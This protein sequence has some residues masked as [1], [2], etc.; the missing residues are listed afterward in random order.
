MSFQ[1]L[2]GALWRTGLALLVAAFSAAAL[3]IPA[4]AQRVSFTG[5]DAARAEICGQS[6]K[7]VHVDPGQPLTLR[8]GPRRGRRTL[9]RLDRCSKG[10]WKAVRRIR[11]HRKSGV[12]VRRNLAKNGMAQDLRARLAGSRPAYARIGVG[13]IV[14]IRF[15]AQ[16]VNQNR[17]SIPCLGAPDSQPYPVHGSLIA[18]RSALDSAH[19]AAT[20][21]VHG[22]G[23]SSFFFHFEDVPGYD[24][25]EQQAR[26]GHASIVV[27]R[28]G[29]PAHDDLPDGDATC[30]P[31]QADM[32]DQVIAALRSGSYDLDGEKSL[33]FERVLLAGHSLGGFITQ[34]AQY[35]FD[36]ADA[37][38]VISY[39]DLPSPL[40]LSTFFAA[41]QTCLTAA[42]RAH[43]D[44]GA[45]NYAPFGRSDADF[46]AGHFHDI[47]PEVERLVLERRNRDTCGELTSALQA[48]LADQLFTRIGIDVPVLVISGRNDALF[49]PPTNR[50][51]AAASYPASGDV[52]LVELSNTGHAVT[53][54]NSRRVFQVEMEEW[55]SAHGG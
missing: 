14:E 42:E 45:P 23:Y 52:Q 20:V 1:E 51:Q 55:L 49:T 12:L 26:A 32:T 47:D 27:D 22:L 38:A 41:N 43:G 34:I 25:A 31:A 9:V 37:I 28:L 36:S 54:G 40:A 39:N 48:L 7:A 3:A 18:P 8:T 50:I 17:T 4:A 44:R 24:Y 29:N 5:G 46:A 10:R 30:I 11:S 2:S 33:R 53:L 15:T 21:Y 13:E 6:K 35:S 16:V 19:P